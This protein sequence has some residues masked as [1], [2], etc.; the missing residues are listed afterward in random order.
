MPGL[1]LYRTGVLSSVT[2]FGKI[3]PLWQRFTSIWQFFDSLFLIWQNA[4]PT[5]AN[6]VHFWANLHAC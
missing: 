2:R 3:L 1:I 6:L 5:L 4:E